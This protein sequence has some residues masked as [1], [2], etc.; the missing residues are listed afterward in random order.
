[1]RGRT[2][3]PKRTPIRDTICATEEI[4]PWNPQGEANAFRLPLDGNAFRRALAHGQGRARLHGQRFGLAGVEAEFIDACCWNRSYDPQCEPDRAQ[5]L[6]EFFS[7][8]PE[9]IARPVCQSLIEGEGEWRDHR[10]RSR[11]VLHLARRGYEPAR[12]ALYQS[13]AFVPESNC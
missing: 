12:E 1:M 9:W 11:L 7:G 13:F 4:G 8:A 6:L 2:C 10:Q 5:W 3:I